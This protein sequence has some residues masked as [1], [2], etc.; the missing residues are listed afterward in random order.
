ME[1]TAESTTSESDVGSDFWGSRGMGL[2]MFD[3]VTYNGRIGFIK[4]M[5]IRTEPAKYQFWVEADKNRLT[6]SDCPKDVVLRIGEVF[7]PNH[8]DGE[9]E[10]KWGQMHNATISWD[11]FSEDWQGFDEEEGI[12]YRYPVDQPNEHC[13]QIDEGLP[14][15]EQ[16]KYLTIEFVDGGP[17]QRVTLKEDEEGYGNFTNYSICQVLKQ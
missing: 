14:K 16:T 17:V 2:N 8:A 12:Y 7:Q 10:F 13:L 6:E 4:N 3:K 9:R 1:P 15:E 11:E 5:E